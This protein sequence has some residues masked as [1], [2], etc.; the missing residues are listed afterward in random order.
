MLNTKDQHNG[1]WNQG[2]LKHAKSK[3]FKLDNHI[4]KNK[5]YLEI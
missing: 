4:G 2:F 3:A 1:T 5:L